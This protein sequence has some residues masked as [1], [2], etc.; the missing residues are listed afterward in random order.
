MKDLYIATNEVIGTPT[1]TSG[2]RYYTNWST[3]ATPGEGAKHALTL[4]KK[5]ESR[6]NP[7]TENPT[8]DFPGVFFER[9]QWPMVE[10]IEGKQYHV[11]FICRIYYVARAVATER[12]KEEAME[13]IIK[14]TDNIMA[15]TM[16]GL[17]WATDLDWVGVDDR[18]EISQAFEILLQDY[19]AASATFRLIGTV[20]F[21]D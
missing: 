15:S 10:R 9:L 12:P 1:G 13:N 19:Y 2:F 11:A 8:E 14:I 20:D 3:T 5:V 4:R 6:P 21:N 18:T 17:T 7:F 16:L